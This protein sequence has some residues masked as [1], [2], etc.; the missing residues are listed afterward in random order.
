[1]VGGDERGE[2]LDPADRV[3]NAH[4]AFV[5]MALDKL[6]AASDAGFDVVI[7]C[8]EDVLPLA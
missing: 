5:T 3:A 8:D 2:R 6:K 7:A 1:M 4:D